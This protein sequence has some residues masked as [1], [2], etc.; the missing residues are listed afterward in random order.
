[1]RTRSIAMA[2]AIVSAFAVS[3]HAADQFVGPDWLKRPTADMI[4]SAWPTEALKKGRSGRT[5]LSCEVSVQGALFACRAVSEEPAG[6][7]FG[8]AAILMTPQLLMK[9]ATLNGKPVLSRVQIPIAFRTEGAVS[10]EAVGPERKRLVPATMAWPQAPSQADVVAA[11]PEKARKAGIGGLASVQCNFGSDGVP[12]ACQVMRE[13]P[14]GYAF[15]VA[16]KSLAKK[17]RAPPE[18]VDG[19]PTSRAMV[20]LPFAFSPDMLTGGDPVVGKPVWAKAPT[21][22]AIRANLP[23]PAA[24]VDTIRVMLGCRVEQGGRVSGCT[25]EREEP[26]GKGYGA[27]V[28]ALADQFRLSTWTMEGLPAVGGKVS[29]PIRYQFTAEPPPTAAKP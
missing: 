14:K 24:G 2:V 23:K 11:Y 19:T 21:V 16:A 18:L 9:P 15:G 13:E 28:L 6:E 4:R 25:V 7:G 22:E 20:Q 8:A 3:S 29:I 26:A 12:K 27:G 17:F 10:I 1:M 5:V